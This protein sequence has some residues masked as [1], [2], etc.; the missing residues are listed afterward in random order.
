MLRGIGEDGGLLGDDE[1]L[2][3]VAEESL[4]D[5]TT[6]WLTD[7]ASILQSQMEKQV[8]RQVLGAGCRVQCKA[9]L[10]PP[11]QGQGCM[12]GAGAALPLRPPARATPS[13]PPPRLHAW[14]C[15]S[16]PQEAVV[17][18]NQKQMQEIAQREGYG[19]L[20][21][22]F[23]CVADGLRACDAVDSLVDASAIDTLLSNFI[24]PLQSDDISKP[25]AS[26]E[27]LGGAGRRAGSV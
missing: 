7:D 24:V 26:G 23:G 1:G 25:D 9:Q 13:D 4:D 2:G 16:S 8:R 14:A 3:L 21:S 6:E 18:R 20:F 12:P 10:A 5:D 19:P 22:T 27:W 11:G 17:P 15:P